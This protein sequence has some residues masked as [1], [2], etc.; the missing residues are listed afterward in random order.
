MDR[1]PNK[2]ISD[3]LR[4]LCVIKKNEGKSYGK[5]AEELHMS[6][7]TVKYI[8]LKYEKTGEVKNL[9]RSGRPRK[10]SEATD[11]LIVRSIL[12]NR[13]LTAG[14]IRQDLQ[15]GLEK[16]LSEE[17]IRRRIREAGFNGRSPRKKPYLREQNK[18]K[19]LAYANDMVN[20]GIEDWKR[21]LFTD[22]SSF[23]LHG[24]NGA[25]KVWRKPDE[26]FKE[27][28]LMPTFKSGRQ[29]IMI[30]GAMSW[31]GVGVLHFCEGKMNGTK[32]LDLLKTTLPKT[33]QKLDLPDNFILLQDNAP[34][35]TAKIVEEYLILNSIE[36]AQHPPQSPDLNPIEHLWS[37]MGKELQKSPSRSVQDLKENLLKIWN[38]IPV[39]FVQKLILSMPERLHSVIKSK[40]SS[41]K[42]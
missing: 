31:N 34:C 26:E 38:E 18:I 9:H 12:T 5:I 14:E 35:H 16:D 24:S 30:W 10:T 36:K 19:R 32:Y 4:R 2:E 15:I 27:D 29:S 11:R 33:K 28:C 41:T 21:F 17:L 7:S 39:A 40:G 37:Y 6:K 8:V 13:R 22:E 20:L 23:E 42:Y 1:S 3:D 25:L